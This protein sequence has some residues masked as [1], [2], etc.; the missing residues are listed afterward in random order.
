M[1]VCL[2][3]WPNPSRVA[4]TCIIAG[5]AT[6][7]KVIINV[8]SSHTDMTTNVD[9]TAKASQV[10]KP[11]DEDHSAEEIGRP[12]EQTLGSDEDGEW[13]R[14]C[15]LYAQQIRVRQTRLV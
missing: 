6:L 7:N 10:R 8:H 11:S 14:W 15:G 2:I 13:P 5:I 9:L 3:G 4:N 12:R 1:V